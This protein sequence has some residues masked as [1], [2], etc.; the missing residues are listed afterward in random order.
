MCADIN[1]RYVSERNHPSGKPVLNN[2]HKTDCFLK[3]REYERIGT[4]DDFKCYKE[5]CEELPSYLIE[6]VLKL[7]HDID[8]RHICEKLAKPICDEP[9]RVINSAEAQDLI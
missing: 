5:L 8:L 2:V 3:L 4:I 7:I 9:N 1:K 6:D